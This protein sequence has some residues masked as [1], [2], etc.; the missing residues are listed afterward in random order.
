MTGKSI[1]R[2]SYGVLIALMAVA[3]WTPATSA[4]AV[5]SV[6]NRFAANCNNFSV[7]VSVAGSNNDGNN[8]DRFRY[9]ITDGN[10][11]KLYQEDNARIVG[12]SQNSIVANLSYDADG[13]ADGAPG[14]NPVTFSIVELDGNN[15]VISTVRQASYDVSCV[16]ASGT[17]TQSGI[18]HPPEVFKAAVIA[19][20]ALYDQPNGNTIQ[21]LS[22]H[23]G[24][25]WIVVYRSADNQWLSIFVGGPEIVWVPARTLAI[26]INQLP[27][28]P[29]RIDSS[30]TVSPTPVGTSTS[31]PLPGVISVRTTANLNVRNAP[32]SAGAI[33]GRVATGTVLAALG[34]SANNSWV[35]VQFNGIPAWVSSFYVRVFGGRLRD[36]PV[37]R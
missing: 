25:S 20:S 7:D 14:K 35:L 12:T 30:V 37:V 26:N 33:L 13:A 17:A 3:A 21:G 8:A 6:I 34:R 36:L 5:G 9:L 2:I 19:D 22:T 11:K 23:T 32:S 29:V 1:L 18:F 10:G 15:N 16:A 31:V 28:R 27:L 4:Y 24:Q